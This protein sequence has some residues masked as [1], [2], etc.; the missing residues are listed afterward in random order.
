MQVSLRT[1]GIVACSH[2]CKTTI[3]LLTL[4]HSHQDQESECAHPH[5]P[6]AE[7]V[8]LTL[9]STVTKQSTWRAHQHVGWGPLRKCSGRRSSRGRCGRPTVESAEVEPA[10]SAH[11][12]AGIST[13]EFHHL[14]HAWVARILSLPILQEYCRRCIGCFAY[15]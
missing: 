14:D 7:L 2:S 8:T 11:Q 13:S 10:D 3:L 5:P 9:P 4:Q 12:G 1:F 15:A 6:K